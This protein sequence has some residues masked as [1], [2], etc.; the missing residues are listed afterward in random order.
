MEE[1]LWEACRDGDVEEVAK[2]LQNSQINTNW[3]DSES[4][5]ITPFWIACEKRTY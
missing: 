2:L 4:S 3:Q 1:K 5:R